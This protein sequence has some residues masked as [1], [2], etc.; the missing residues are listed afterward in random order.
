MREELERLATSFLDAFNS[1]D[2]KAISAFVSPDVTYAG[3]GAAAPGATGVDALLS[4]VDSL[5]AAAPTVT[6]TPSRW[7]IDANSGAIAG[8]VVW[9][10][11]EAEP[12]LDSATPLAGAERPPTVPG[13]LIL[14]VRDNRITGIR[15]AH[16]P[17]DIDPHACPVFH[18]PED[19][20]E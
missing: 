6:G 19:P 12:L 13:M 16:P 17:I 14:D 15:E 18:P 20:I 9:S 7:I 1:G 2:V 4:A 3:P 5:R 10:T 8:E 11:A